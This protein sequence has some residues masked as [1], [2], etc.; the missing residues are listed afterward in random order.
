MIAPEPYLSAY[1][2]LVHRAVL[3][4]RQLARASMGL[5]R[6]LFAR[7]SIA[8]VADLQDAIHVVTELLANWEGCHEEK[9]R[10]TYLAAFDKK[11]SANPPLGLLLLPTLRERLPSA[12]P[13]L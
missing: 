1:L 6:R 8:Q 5:P 2:H 12:A 9:L 10:S 3:V 11:W 4:S 7:E 13:D